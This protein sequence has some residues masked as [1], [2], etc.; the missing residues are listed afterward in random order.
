[1]KWDKVFAFV[2]LL[3][4]TGTLIC[5]VL[6]V[7][8]AALAG[9]AAVLGMVTMFPWLIPLSQHK[10]WIFLVAAILIAFTGIILYR[11]H[12]RLVCALLGGKGC[13]V[14]GKFSKTLFWIALGI[15]VVG[16]TASYGVGWILNLS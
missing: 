2:A 13:E 16:F 15:Y 7:V 9:G 3:G 4:S 5:C 14:T 8:V 11:P 6:P 1:M 10:V 12:S